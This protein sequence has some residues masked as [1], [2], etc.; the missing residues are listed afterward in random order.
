MGPVFYA[1]EM[2]GEGIKGWYSEAV[3][4]YSGGYDKTISSYVPKPVG[5]LVANSVKTA[6]DIATRFAPKPL[7]KF[8][9]EVL[10]D[11]TTTQE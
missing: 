9:R 6:V 2:A 8:A 3:R 5:T 11:L 1:A 10:D 7:K 4:L